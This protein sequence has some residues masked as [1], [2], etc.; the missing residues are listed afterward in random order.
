MRRALGFIARG[1]S[2]PGCLILLVAGMLWPALVQAQAIEP[3]LAPTLTVDRLP[4]DG[5]PFAVRVG[6]D[7]AFSRQEIRDIRAALAISHDLF[8]D[9]RT[10]P[11]YATGIYFGRHKLLAAAQGDLVRLGPQV[12]FFGLAEADYWDRTAAM[13]APEDQLSHYNP[14]TG[15]VYVSAFEL[16]RDA[17]A[18]AVIASH[19][20]YAM[21]R[22]TAGALGFG[23]PLV[24]FLADYLVML[25]RERTNPEVRAEA[26]AQAEASADRL[27]RR[28]LRRVITRLDIGRPDFRPQVDAMNTDSTVGW[29]WIL[30]RLDQAGPYFFR[31]YFRAVRAAFR[32]A[33]GSAC[34]TFASL[35]HCLVGLDQATAEPALCGARVATVPTLYDPTRCTA[36]PDHGALY[37]VLQQA[38]MVGDRVA[39]ACAGA[40]AADCNGLAEAWEQT[41]GYLR[42]S[43]Q[44]AAYDFLDGYQP[45]RGGR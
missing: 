11:P 22:W 34:A 14:L 43:V 2:G 24:P 15:R 41:R 44:V 31:D 16:P 19:A 35:R 6:H 39:A 45:D 28:L 8:A 3:D 23:V 17:M 13:A 37:G 7:P 29:A 21:D 38:V 5:G 32:P 42:S 36:S 27:T 33:V 18:A 10:P 4:D 20:R 26:S 12:D 25:Y 9:N 30:I 1:V 40:A